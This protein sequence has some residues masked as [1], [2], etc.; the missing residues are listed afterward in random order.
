VG[1]GEPLRDLAAELHGARRR[2]DG[3]LV[4]K[5][6][7]R[8]ALDQLHDDPVAV[9]AL[10]EIVDVNDRR[11]VEARHGPGL[12]PQA[13]AAV[14]QSGA[15][16]LQGD[17]ALQALIPGRQTSP[18]PPL[19]SS[20]SS[21]YGPSLRGGSG[22]GCSGFTCAFYTKSWSACGGF[23]GTARRPKARRARAASAEAL[24]RLPPPYPI[25]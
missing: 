2:E 18:I 9:L 24:R 17:P 16:L 4:E 19:P 21:R 22:E 14:A 7:E 11:M 3:L 12:A 6:A 15:D 5:V 13:F 25:Q 20:R 23:E 10:Q 8:P 1:L